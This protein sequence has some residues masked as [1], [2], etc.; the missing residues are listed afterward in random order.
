MSGFEDEFRRLREEVESS[1]NRALERIN[2]GSSRISEIGSKVGLEKSTS[3]LW[4]FLKEVKGLKHEVKRELL[5]AREGLLR[6]LRSFRDRL[7]EA[8]AGEP[9]MARGLKESF[10]ELRDF[11]EDRFDEAEDRLDEFLD[12]VEDVED[13]I[14]DRIREL[15]GGVREKEAYVMKFRVPEVKIPDIG[16]LVEE[17]ISKAWSGVPSMIVSS[18]RLPKADLDLIDALVEA[19]I[20]KSRNEGIAF[21][22][23]K[24]IEASSEWLNKVREKLEE[25]KR[26]Q[27]ET[28]KEMEKMLGEAPGR[29]EEK[30]D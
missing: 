20:L 29:G 6:E 5:E 1:I 19:G 11:F 16:K 14:R 15:K 25:I 21:F 7:R 28:K 23:H 13:S 17:S 24:G 8:S 3:G 9:G 4:E 22:A 27:E 12:R 26:L 2:D 18:V 30:E 10:E